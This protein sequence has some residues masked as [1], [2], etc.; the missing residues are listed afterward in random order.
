MSDDLTAIRA[1]L[2]SYAGYH[3]LDA[4]RLADRQIRAYIGEALTDLRERG[5]AADVVAR[6]D[7]LL[8]RCEL[9]DQHVIRALERGRLEQPEREAQVDAIDRALV[10]RT[11]GLPALDPA[12][13][14]PAVTDLEAD[15]DRRNAIIVALGPHP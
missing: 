9:G 6:I 14:G 3:D 11:A 10:E 13:A 15:F 12:D 1:I 5:P 7:A 2:P 4:Q 8:V